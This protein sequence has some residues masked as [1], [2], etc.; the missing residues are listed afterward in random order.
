MEAT[1]YRTGEKALLT[2]NVSKMEEISN[3]ADFNSSPT[4]NT[5]FVLTGIYESKAGVLEH[6][7]TPTRI[8]RLPPRFASWLEKCEVTP[9][10]AASIFNSLW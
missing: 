6:R 7:N 3:A 1:H 10:L 2:Y 4:G 9:V 5:S 8:G